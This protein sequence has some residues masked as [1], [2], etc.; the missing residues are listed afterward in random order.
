MAAVAGNRKD[1]ELDIVL[2]STK[3]G[4][5][6]RNLT[7]GFDKDRGFEYIAV[8]GSRWNS[9]PWMSWSPVGDRLA[10]FVRTEK[11]RTLLIQNVV[12]GKTEQRVEIE[13]P[14]RARVARLLARRQVRG[15]LRAPERDRRHLQ[16]RSRERRDHQPDEGRLRRLRADRTRRTASTWST[17]RASAATTSCSASTSIRGKKTQ[18]TF[19]T[20]DEAAAS[21]IDAKTLV[22]ASTAIDPAKPVSPD[23]AAQRQH[24]QHLDAEPGDRGAAAVHRRAQRQPVGR[25]AQRRRHEQDRVRDLLQDRVRR[26]HARSEAADRDGGVRRLRRAGTDHRLP[27]AALAH[28]GEGEPAPQGH[29]RE[30]VPRRPSADQRRRH[31]RRRPVRRHRR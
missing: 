4:S 18:L 21:F 8:P 26:P 12:T 5:V 19:G 2:L 24:L 29:V 13:E 1:Y 10:Y 28:A 30:A 25:P 23:D 3:D 31:Q 15:L 9:V 16:A 7:P 17:W 11:Q 14:G 6:I 27:A 22:F 20:H